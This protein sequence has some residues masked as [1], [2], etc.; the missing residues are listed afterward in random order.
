M[1]K[2]LHI[3]DL[4]KVYSS[5]TKV[6][7]ALDS[8]NLDLEK[9]KILS[10]IGYSGCGKST[11]LKVISGLVK[12]DCGHINISDNESVAVVF[13]E[14]RLIKS[15][16]IYKNLELAIISEKCPMKRKSNITEIL[17]LLEL[18]DFKESYPSQLSGGMAQRVG[19]G[20]ALCMKPSL[21]LLDEPFSALDALLRKKMQEELI[22]IYLKSNMTIVFITHDVNEAVILGSEVIVMD[23]GKVVE[24]VNV[25]LPYPRNSSNKEFIQYR[26]FLLD[27]IYTPRRTR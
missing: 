14:P 7:K 10:V 2:V 3:R 6:T 11:L 20:R 24:K 16:S 27:K 18:S 5:N 21:L 4:T 9:G 15:K 12:P 26:D 17:N 8:I 25:D 1:S 22:D 19:L 13:Q 23:G